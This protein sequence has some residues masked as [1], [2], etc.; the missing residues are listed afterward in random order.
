MDASK[1][2]LMGI[3]AVLLFAACRSSDN[4]AMSYVSQTEVV[5]DSAFA[6]RA[7]NNDGYSQIGSVSRRA[8]GDLVVFVD[9]ETVVRLD[10][11][12]NQLASATRSGSGPGEWRYVLWAGADSVGIGVLDASNLRL[13]TLSPDLSP[14]REIQVPPVALGGVVA[15]R[16]S[17]G[18]FVSLLDPPTIPGTGSQ[19]FLTNLIRWTP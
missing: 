10:A 1:Q 7:N 14:R 12:G 18:S 15:G 4:S 13:V 3:A 16:L 6:R 9:G 19:R 17:D 11:D 2:A 8:N 5:E